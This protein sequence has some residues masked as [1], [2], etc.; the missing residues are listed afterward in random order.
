MTLFGKRTTL[1][2]DV[3]KNTIR[4]GW[5]LIIKIS[6]RIKGARKATKMPCVTMLFKK[7]PKRELKRR[8]QGVMPDISAVQI[9]ILT[10]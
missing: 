7:A 1:L 10:D 9:V 8:L 4:R 5:R 3:P 6:Q 2:S